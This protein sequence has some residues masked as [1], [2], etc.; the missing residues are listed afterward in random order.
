MF[1]L[2]PDL[3]LRR[4]LGLVLRTWQRTETGFNPADQKRSVRNGTE[5]THWP[6]ENKILL[7]PYFHLPFLSL[8]CLSSSVSFSPLWCLFC[9]WSPP[10]FAFPLFT[11]CFP[12]ALSTVH[13]F[14]HFQSFSIEN[15]G[16]EHNGI[17]ELKDPFSFWLLYFSLRFLLVFLIDW[18][19]VSLTLRGLKELSSTKSCGFEHV[20]LYYLLTPT[21]SSPVLTHT[22]IHTL[23]SLR[24][25]SISLWPGKYR[26]MEIGIYE[27]GRAY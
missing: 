3:I 4:V 27:L 23:L 26:Y 2:R 21:R 1:P 22:Y 8:T 11:I 18:P 20:T 12:C 7:H 9:C 10:A 14:V 25:Y 5:R 15:T 24:S 6:Q 19:R 13:S 16:I 17:G